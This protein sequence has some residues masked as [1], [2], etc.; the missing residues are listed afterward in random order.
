MEGGA[1]AR[2]PTPSRLGAARAPAPTLDRER[3]EPRAVASVGP[4]PRHRGAF[5]RAPGSPPLS[6]GITG[7]R[8]RTAA[9]AP[10]WPPRGARCRAGLRRPRPCGAWLKRRSRS[11]G[12]VAPSASCCD[13]DACARARDGVCACPA[14]VLQRTLNLLPLAG[15]RPSRAAA[16]DSLRIVCSQSGTSIAEP[17][18]IGARA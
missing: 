12:L 2:V 17:Y 8:A 15:R 3:E 6:E 14:D 9:G 18:T 16:Q 7:A 13:V 10:A 5:P 1:E 11:P 4:G